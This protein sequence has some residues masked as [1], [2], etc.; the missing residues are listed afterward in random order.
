[1]VRMFRL[2]FSW[3]GKKT[4]V[5]SSGLLLTLASWATDVGVQNAADG[6]NPAEQTQTAV[7][8]GP[9][10][11]LPSVLQNGRLVS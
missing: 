10:A 3:Y 4:I 9:S 2:I 8:V 7:P 5:F 6:S 11:S 1:M